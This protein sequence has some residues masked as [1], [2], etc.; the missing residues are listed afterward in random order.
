MMPLHT[1]AI[2]AAALWSGGTDGVRLSVECEAPQIDP[3]RSVEIVLKLESPPGKTARLPDLRPRL[4]GFSLAESFEEPE[5]KTKDGG[6]VASAVWLLRPEP[7]AKRYAVAPFAVKVDGGKPFVAGPIAFT[8]PAPRERVE[9]PIEADLSKDLPPF[10]WKLVSWCAGILAAAAAVLFLAVA[11]A[12]LAARRVREHFM[13][14][15]ERARAEL[16]RLKKKGLPG[17]GRFKD[18][19][20]ELTMVVRRYFKRKYAVE[21]PH[22]TT[23]E[24]FASEAVAASGAATPAL[25]AFMAS[26]DLVKFA[27]AEATPETADLAM[28]AANAWLDADSAKEAAAK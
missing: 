3:G 24:F 25:H 19:Y 8:Q 15:I 9:G 28:D 27:G 20:V 5:E 21:A 11:A 23:E 22:M 17:R 6:T 26:A 7:C 2:L 12:R 1:A 10:G 4:R 14:P 16:Q 13:S 18:F